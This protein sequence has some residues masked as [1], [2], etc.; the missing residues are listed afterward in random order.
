MK[1]KI[2]FL[3]HY[4]EI[5]G[6][7]S[8]L[9][10]LLQAFD[11]KRYDVDLF[12]YSHQGDFMAFIPK[13]VNLLPEIKSYSMF[14]RPMKEV[15]KNGQF[16]VLLAR[17]YAKL[18]TKLYYSFVK[19]DKPHVA[20]LGY[21]GKYVTR[22]LPQIQ[23]KVEYDLAVSFLNPHDITL[24]KVTAKK[25]VCW[26]H[27]DYSRIDVNVALEL[28]V[29]RGFD[30]IISISSDVTK[31]FLKVFPSLENKIVEIENILSPAFVRQ[32]AEEFDATPEMRIGE[33]L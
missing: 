6:A 4:L 16:G 31:T 32:R 9:I 26:I 2:I 15:L 19:T 8:A 17:L 24:H 21:I 13:Q 22:V 20:G 33:S 10:G 14:E 28:P 3:I 1:P 29:W 27:T 7:E 25:K 18:K 30:H 11:Y 12:V 23:P 5:G